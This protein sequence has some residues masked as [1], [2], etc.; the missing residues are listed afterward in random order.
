MLAP[1]SDLREIVSGEILET[2]G[3]H[4]SPVVPDNKKICSFPSQLYFHLHCAL[5]SVRVRRLMTT[6]GK[7]K[8]CSTNIKGD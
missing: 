1:Q 8:R 7:V 4:A 3:V 5:T 2:R 6:L